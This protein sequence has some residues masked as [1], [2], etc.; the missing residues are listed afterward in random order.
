MLI[1]QTLAYL[2]AQLLGPLVQF[3]TAIVLTYLL[4]AADYGITMLIFAS[5]E[6]V[7][8]LCL[9]WWTTYMMRYAG[10]LPDD[11]A[12]ERFRQT[13]RGVLMVTGLLQIIGTFG[14][15]MVSVPGASLGFYLAAALFT[16]SRSYLHF[17]AERA[18]KEAAIVDYSLIQIVAPLLGL[19]LAI[20]LATAI[21]LTPEQILFLFAIGQAAIGF[22]VG[23]RLGLLRHWGPID[24]ETFRAAFAFGYPVVVSSAFGWVSTNGIRFIVQNTA[25]IAALGLM[26]VGWWLAFRLSNLAAMLVTAA[27]YPLAVKAMENGDRPAALRQFSDNSALLLAMI[28]PATFGVIAINEPMVRLLVAA[29][30]HDMTIAIL[31]W[32]LACAAIRA[33]RA[34]GWDQLYLLFEAPY[35]MLVVEVIEAIVTLAA[36]LV[37]VLYG[38]VLGAVIGTT[39]AGIAVAIGDY[40][41]LHVRF[42]IRAPFWQFARIL[43]AAATMFLAL[44]ALP[45]LGFAITPHWT[46]V[47]IT[48]TI[49]GMIYG[50]ALAALFP[51]LAMGSAQFVL[52]RLR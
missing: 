8:I 22:H 52:A 1:R 40:A 31:P 6:L 38:G 11:A 48:I 12:R 34:H 20:L 36:T 50:A 3:A 17:L 18:R 19:G 47:L 23:R 26:S 14:V 5:Q 46:S 33:F 51:R 13:E 10:S 30:F 44:R 28:A 43:L 15:V 27:A 42:G 9:A 45:G 25:G 39:V 32:A 49:G 41:F 7:F 21:K 37:G 16:F 2:P 4:G 24:R 35:P 29:D